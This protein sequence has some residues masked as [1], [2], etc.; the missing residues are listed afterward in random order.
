MIYYKKKDTAI[1]AGQR[2]TAKRCSCF[3]LSAMMAITWLHSQK[4]KA[5]NSKTPKPR[6]MS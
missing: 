2:L 6:S 1:L 3:K 4:S 5:S